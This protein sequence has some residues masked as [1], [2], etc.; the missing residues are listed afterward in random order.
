MFKRVLPLRLVSTLTAATAGFIMFLALG[1]LSYSNL[2]TVTVEEYGFLVWLAYLT[3]MLGASLARQLLGE[4]R[5]VG[6]QLR[7]SRTLMQWAI[8]LSCLWVTILF[9]KFML[10]TEHHVN[11]LRRT[12]CQHEFH[13]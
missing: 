6:L 5:Q 7:P 3:F 9:V 11:C 12:A 13:K 2:L 10:A 8:A 4:S 1:I